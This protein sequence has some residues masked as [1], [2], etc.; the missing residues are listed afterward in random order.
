M[1]CTILPAEPIVCPWISAISPRSSFSAPG[2]CSSR[3]PSRVRQTISCSARARSN[4]APASP[5]NSARDCSS[6]SSAA[7]VSL[8]F[9]C[10]NDFATRW[11]TPSQESVTI[12]VTSAVPPLAA[13]T[14]SASVNIGPVPLFF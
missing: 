1:F 5:A 13:S 14:L 2:S 6:L 9:P 11:R 4:S 10:P 3:S 7:S 12:A 8:V